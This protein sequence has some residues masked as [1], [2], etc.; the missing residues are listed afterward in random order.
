[1]PAILTNTTLISA[2][3]P[4]S[5]IDG[6]SD[7]LSS[8]KKVFDYNS[9]GTGEAL[10]QL[11]TFSAQVDS[12]SQ[13]S[14][15][16]KQQFYNLTDSQVQIKVAQTPHDARYLLFA[17]DFYENFGKYDEAVLYLQR[18]AVESPKKPT[19]YFDLGQAY[20]GKG[21]YA[22]AFNAFQTGY[23]LAP[24]SSDGQ[25]LYA[26]GAVYDKNSAVLAEI[27]P[28]IGTSTV[29]TDNRF[30]Q[31]YAAIG[32][33]QTVIDILTERLVS[34]PTNLQYKLSLASAY[35]QTGQKQKSISLLNEI[36]AQDPAFKTQ[37]EKY[38]QQ[39]QN[40]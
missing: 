28:Q 21:D 5:S 26:T 17:G 1:V 27:L 19:I 37:G 14:D 6:L 20:V 18:A 29:I 38:I 34:D 33:Y 4:P 8:F 13:V 25:I 35:L 32:N 11:I 10:E 12:A 30:L 9:F 36:I 40:Q 3:T 23:Q 7:N 22:S 39:I 24:D 31:A 15:D 2:I 16:L